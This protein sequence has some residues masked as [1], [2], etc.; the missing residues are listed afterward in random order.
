MNIA[1]SRLAQVSIYLRGHGMKAAQ[2]VACNFV[3]PYLIYSYVAEKLGPAPALLA[4]SAPPIVWGVIQFVRERKV[5]AISILV[6]S[7]MVLSLLAF[8]GGGG[9]KFLQLR[10]NM[11][12]GLVGLVFLGSAAI[13]QPLSMMIA[14]A[15]MDA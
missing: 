12:T 2:E 10:E 14:S 7:G 4:A 15:R 8:A 3:L 11:M 9:V 13:G 5:D 6:L 1:L